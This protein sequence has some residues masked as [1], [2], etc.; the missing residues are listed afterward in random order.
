M[1]ATSPAMHDLADLVTEAAAESP[2]K[3]AVVEAGGRSLTWAE[4]DDEVGRVA[5]G[6][7]A[8]G[9]VAGYRVP[10]PWATGSS[11]SRRTSASCAPSSSRSRS[12]PRTRR[13][14]GP[15]DR[16]LG[17]R[18]VVGDPD[19]AG[20]VREAVALVVRAVDGELAEEIGEMDPDLVARAVKP[21]VVVIDAELVPGE[22]SYDQL[23]S[24]EARCDPADPGPREA[25]G[26]ALHQRHLGPS[27]RRDAHPPRAAREHRPGRSRPASD[28][29]WRRRGPRGAS[30]FHVYGLNAVLGGVLRHRAKLVLADR[31][32]PQGTL[33]LIEDEACSVV[34]VAPPVFAYWHQPDQERG[35]DQLASGSAR[36]G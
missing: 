6:L 26:P 20:A 34:P 18:L 25:R 30:L 7:A 35:D 3:L 32:D 24:H 23:R 9:M 1:P 16:R 17:S 31:F 14:A 2:D 8:A 33:D 27:P 19:T 4:L 12:T 22:H 36:S 13:R 29:P 5:T 11:S 21:R 28:D 15:T 10:W